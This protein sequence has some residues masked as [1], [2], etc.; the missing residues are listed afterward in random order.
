MKNKDTAL[1]IYPGGGYG[2]FFEWCLTYFSGELESNSSPLISATGSAHKF[3]GH[4]L[5]FSNPTGHH[6]ECLT[7]DQYLNSDSNFTFARSHARADVNSAQVYVDKYGNAFK[8]I[9]EPRPDNTVMLEIF[10]NLLHKVSFANDIVDKIYNASSI[11]SNDDKWEVREKLSFY[12]RSRYLHLDSERRHFT[13]PN[14][15]TIPIARLHNQFKS[16]IQEVFDSIGIKGDPSREHEMDTVLADWASNQKFLNIDSLCQQFVKAAI[17]GEE[18]SWP[19]LATLPLNIFIESYIQMLLR[20]L[21]GL[22]IR[23]YNLNVFPTNAKNLKE[24]LINVQP[25]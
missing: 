4:P 24:L 8:H 7:V 6:L 9:I 17:S 16:C 5:D 12:L 1:I 20:D 22:E 14:V 21:H 3:W 15:I 18:Y 11:T 23:C 13:A 10:L 25:V 2:T 19:R